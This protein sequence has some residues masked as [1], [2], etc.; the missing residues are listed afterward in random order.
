MKRHLAGG[1]VAQLRAATERVGYYWH[2]NPQGG[3]WQI[4]RLEDSED[5]EKLMRVWTL[6][7]GGEDGWMTD[8]GMAH[9][10]VEGPIA[11]PRSGEQPA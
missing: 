2:R 8:A 10:D 3:M 4:A 9:Y 1:T 11:E 6:F 7:D 5:D